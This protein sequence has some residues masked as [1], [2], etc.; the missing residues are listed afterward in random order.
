MS[1]NATGR[2]QWTPVFN[3]SRTDADVTIVFVAPNAIK[4]RSPVIDPFFKAIYPTTELTI[5]EG[6][7]TVYNPYDQV[8]VMG[9]V[10]QYQICTDEY[11]CTNLGGQDALGR[12]ILSLGLNAAQFVTAQRMIYM[13][14]YANTYSSINGIGPD[15]LKVW[16]Q[17]YDFIAPKLPQ[18][19]WKI[20]VEGWFETTLAKWQAF[21]VE[22]AINTAELGSHRHV[23]FPVTNSTL[24]SVWRSQCQNQKVSNVGGYQNVS[25]FGFAFTWA[26]GGFLVLL[27]WSLKECISKERERREKMFKPDPSSKTHLTWRQQN[28]KSS[29]RRIA[30][31]IDGTLQQNR[32]ALR[33]V[34]YNELKGGR[35]DVPYLNE[36]T[37]APL[38]IKE[39]EDEATGDTTYVRTGQ[40]IKA[41]DDLGKDGASSS[42][43]PIQAE[44]AEGSLPKSAHSK[45]KCA[46]TQESSTS[47]PKVENQAIEEEPA[48]RSQVAPSSNS[49]S[50][51]HS[52][53]IPHPLAE[54]SQ[55]TH[56]DDAQGTLP[57]SLR[58]SLEA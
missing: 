15:A 17:V 18:N 6:T 43:H 10:E 47:A 40:E 22:F 50:L 39:T 34:G 54:E 21:M 1:H 38:P 8:S 29:A 9:C 36:M 55:S 49:E 46:S 42:S 52:S 51:G 11:H 57:D 58:H 31:N 27:A 53:A 41:P 2:S 44:K 7:I 3:I 13:I 19:Q 20:E 25:V 16:D 30:W 48:P 45:D 56:D 33:S 24:D 14:S 37:D 35:G 26:I 23:G 5:D 32:L 12:E 28:P 4:Y